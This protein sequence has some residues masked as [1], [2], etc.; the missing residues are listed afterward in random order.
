MRKGIGLADLTQSLTLS[1]IGAIFYSIAG[2][3][4][5]SSGSMS[6]LAVLLGGMTALLTGISISELSN[7]YPL[8]SSLN[9]FSRRVFKNELIEFS[10]LWA[11]TIKYLL[12]TIIVAI[13]FGVFVNAIS[14][15]PII[16]SAI[17]IIVLSMIL[18]VYGIKPSKRLSYALSV[19]GFLT[20]AVLAITALISPRGQGSPGSLPGILSG[21]AISVIALLGFEAIPSLRDHIR[22]PEHNI[23]NS[24]VAAIIIST[25]SYAITLF[26]FNNFAP[27][28]TIMAEVMSSSYLGPL[29]FLIAVSLTAVMTVTLFS[30]AAMLTQELGET[31]F[32]PDIVA[33]QNRFESPQNAIIMLTMTAVILSFL[34]LELVTEIT[35]LIVLSTFALT[36]TL[37]LLSCNN[38]ERELQLTS[39]SGIILSLILALSLPLTAQV[40]AIIILFSGL[41]LFLSKGIVVIRK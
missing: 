39:A 37:T 18:L 32:L 4:L 27:S 11:T 3:I 17:T 34:G 9:E 2:V 23:R 13:G 1:I 41:P 15:I 28:L 16:S 25:L 21:A 40:I 30:K 20:L 33:E 38:D 10:A 5:V 8:D 24:I 7:K 14:Q 19:L 6:W 36:N 29:L 22:H 31:G 26:A 12:L 35:A